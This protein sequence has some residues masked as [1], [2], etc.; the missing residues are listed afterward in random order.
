[1][2]IRLKESSIVIEILEN[3]DYLD[4]VTS[5]LIGAK[6]RNKKEEL[7]KNIYYICAKNVNYHN[8][9]FFKKLIKSSHK[10][11]VLHVD[12]KDPLK[13]HYKLL[14]SDKNDSMQIIR[15]RYLKLV[16]TYHPDRVSYSDSSLVEEYTHQ[17]QKIQKAYEILKLKSAS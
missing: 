13:Q 7:L 8:P 15:K 14:R 2:R 3:S 16:K 5:A 11:I 10:N 6:C 9:Q 12:K 4:S 17:F 1:M